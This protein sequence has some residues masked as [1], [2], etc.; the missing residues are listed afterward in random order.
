MSRT[1]AE[2]Q[3]SFKTIQDP[4]KISGEKKI[5]RRKNIWSQISL[6]KKKVYMQYIYIYIYLY[7]IMKIQ[8]ESI[9]PT[10][11]VKTLVLDGPKANTIAVVGTVDSSEK[12]RIFF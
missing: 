3:H 12:S 5:F 10:D 11:N 4:K 1:Q 2:T 9:F 6:P 8:K 7:K